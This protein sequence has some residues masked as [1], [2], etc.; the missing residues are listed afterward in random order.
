M[1][2]TYTR[3]EFIDE[4]GNFILKEIKG[5]GIFF[6]TIVS[7]A[8]LESSGK[9]GGEWKVAGSLLSQ[10][11]KNLFG[12][13]AYGNWK[14]RVYN[15]D[16]REESKSRASYTEKNAPFRAYRSYKESIKDYVKFLKE[17]KRYSDAG[18][19]TAPDYYEQAKRLKKAGYATASNY[20]DSVKSI[21]SPLKSNFEDAKR[22]FQTKQIVKHTLVYTAIIVGSFFLWKKFVSKK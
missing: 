11:A 1:Q 2:N 17:N 22:K 6:E 18:V 8:I 16:T 10:D 3:K 15:I 13:K 7:Q 19:F 9:V 5:T 12:I 14:G 20:A 4:F 21:A